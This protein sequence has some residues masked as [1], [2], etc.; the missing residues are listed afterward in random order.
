MKERFRRNNKS[1]N[2]TKW[3]KIEKQ[4]YRNIF[5]YKMGNQNSTTQKK[6]TKEERVQIKD[7]RTYIINLRKE[8]I[9]NIQEQETKR[10]KTTKKY[11]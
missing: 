2:N 10:N 5:P 7:E 1:E 4:I 9:N 11:R 3:C 8:Q 6:R